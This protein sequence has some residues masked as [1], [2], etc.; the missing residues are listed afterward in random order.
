MTRKVINLLKARNKAFKTGD[1]AAYSVARSNLKKGIKKA[2]DMYS[3]SL[4]IKEP[5][6]LTVMSG[7][8]MNLTTFLPGLAP[9]IPYHLARINTTDEDRT[10]TIALTI[11]EVQRSLQK[12]N[13]KKVPGPNG[14]LGPVL[15]VYAEQ[16]A[17]VLADIFNLFLKLETVPQCLKS[18]TIVAAPKKTNISKMNDYRT[19]TLTPTVLKSIERLLLSHIKANVPATSWD[20][21]QFAYRANRS[22]GYHLSRF[23]YCPDPPQGE[24]HIHEKAFFGLQLC[25]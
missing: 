20:T 14:V 15:R 19:I 13:A 16:L 10:S 23:P 5:S 12:V 2:K 3:P 17:G 7:W 11:Q 24:G 4:T 25:F 8:L 1:A 6:F 9:A 22:R 18:V 21:H